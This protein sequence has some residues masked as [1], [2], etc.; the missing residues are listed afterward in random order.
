[1]EGGNLDSL[2]VNTPPSLGFRWHGN[3]LGNGPH[4]GTQFPGNGD[5]DLMGMFACGHQL[6][7]PCA[8]PDLGLPADG[9]DRGGELFQAPLAGAD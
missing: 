4:E 7:I 1:M 9:L 5:H 3:L 6:A 2:C 8:E